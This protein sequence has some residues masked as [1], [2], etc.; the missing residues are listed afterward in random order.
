MLRS[1]KPLWRKS[2]G[3]AP[4]EDI[5]LNGL[6]LEGELAWPYD[7]FYRPTIGI[8]VNG[9]LKNIV[10]T[11]RRPSARP[12]GSWGC[13]FEC[14]IEEYEDLL[15]DVTIRC[16]ETGSVLKSFYKSDR[17]K[18]MVTEN[19]QSVRDIIHAV[20]EA[21]EVGRCDGF[22]S[23]L[24]LSTMD[25]IDL[26][27]FCVLGRAVD[28]EG[29][30]FYLSRMCSGEIT[31]LDVRDRLLVSDEFVSEAKPKAS[32]NFLHWLVWGGLGE[33]IASFA[34]RKGYADSGPGR[35]PIRFVERSSLEDIVALPRL[36]S[37]LAK[38]ALGPNAGDELISLWQKEHSRMLH[39]LTQE[40]ERRIE[41]RHQAEP[42]GQMQFSGLLNAMQVGSAGKATKK[43]IA[44]RSN[45]IG[46][47]FF[48]PFMRLQA[49]HYRLIMLMHA[50]KRESEY[51][52][53]FILLEVVYQDLLI[54]WHLIPET[55]FQ[56]A[57]HAFEF[58]I[59]THDI[60]LTE[61]RFEF[62]LHK[63]FDLEV[64]V[65]DLSLEQIG[66]ERSPG[67][68]PQNWLPLLTIASAG[69]STREGV[70]SKADAEGHIL[71]G[72]Y[73][74]LLPAQ[75]VLSVDYRIASSDAR[76]G[77]IHIEAVDSHGVVFA[78]RQFII[79]PSRPTSPLEFLFFIAPPDA[80]TSQL[81]WMEFRVSKTGKIDVVV[82]SVNV[83][84]I[85]STR[86]DRLVDQFN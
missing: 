56:Q 67:D 53:S 51:R 48:G 7:V 68:V 21:R 37:Y 36:G 38:I 17:N 11:N 47:V 29:L 73:R 6:R 12:S 61:P 52:E 82:K 40:V 32:A 45:A 69:E 85:A 41:A 24:D 33:A 14:D 28:P 22:P 39:E 60:R 72:P 31:I 66:A 42:S 46:E 78:H 84:V 86:R 76:Y 44:S 64:E 2:R 49:G 58:T 59:P 55:K 18:T 75:Y 43:G 77:E 50:A 80:Q 23:F 54:A 35:D 8:F 19:I 25:Q 13:L 26:L 9:L 71:C 16:L 1:L 15:D 83:K 81:P 79:D 20:E 65:F 57:V 63:R 34:M 10:P 30:N 74:A 70:A 27:Y 3:P 4:R 62:R 5:R